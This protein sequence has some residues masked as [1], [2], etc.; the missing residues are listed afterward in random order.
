MGED[1]VSCTLAQLD[2]SD[3]RDDLAA[4]LDIDIVSDMDVEHLHLVGIVKRCAFDN[5]SAQLYR[6]EIRYRSHCSCPAYLIIDRYESGECLLSLELVCNR[7]T[8]EFGCVAELF[9]IW[10]FIY[11]DDDSVCGK[12]KILSFSVPVVDEVFYLINT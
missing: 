2:S 3:F 1:D 12:W 8:W 11:L 6:L 4:L 10:K 7:P 5:G 9:L